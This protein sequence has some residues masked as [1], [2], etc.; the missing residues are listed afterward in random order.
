MEKPCLGEKKA[1][2]LLASWAP[3]MYV[4]LIHT[5]KTLEPHTSKGFFVAFDLAV[6]IIVDK[7]L[8]Q[9]CEG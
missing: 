9:G 1:L 7:Q 6:K 4:D 8:L 2:V 3:G 5:G